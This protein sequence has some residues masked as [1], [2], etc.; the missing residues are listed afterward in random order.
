MKRISNPLTEDLW[1]PLPP[2]MKHHFQIGNYQEI[3]AIRPIILDEFAISSIRR[4]ASNS[5]EHEAIAFIE[6]FDSYKT[7]YL[8]LAANTGQLEFKGTGV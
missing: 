5:R 4:L 8:R 1:M 3:L 6:M 2:G 7:V